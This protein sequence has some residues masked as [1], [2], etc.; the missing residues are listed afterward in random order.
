[1]VAGVQGLGL[2]DRMAQALLR[3]IHSARW[4]M[5]MLVMLCFFCSMLITNDV[6]LITFVPLALTLLPR[7]GL[8]QQLLPVV[9]LQT[10]AANLGSMLTPIGNPQNLYLYT[11]SDMPLGQFVMLLL[12]Y[13][14]ASFLL[15]AVATWCIPVKA[16]EYHAESHT[17][18]T[19]PLSGKL[20]ALYA[21]LF[22]L[23]LMAVLRIVPVIAVLVVVLIA[24]LLF[25]RKVLPRVD[26]GLLIT[27]VCF[28]IFIGNIGHLPAVAQAL[29]DLLTGREV[30]TSVLLCQVISNVPAAVL[31]SSFT[32]D[33]AALLIGTNLGGLGT[34]IASMASLISYRLLTRS[35]SGQTGRYMLQFTVVNGVFLLILLTL[36]FLL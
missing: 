25:D 28:F 21:A 8:S 22:V 17:T 30:L 26:Y 34:L 2:F 31:L 19:T 24:L 36:Y 16:G 20:L 12:P 29:E 33:H 18:A 9:V 11:L 6:A 15:L 7:S 14:L 23:S 27:F 35:V 1:V 10:V 13:T 32:A 4:L 3:H 5:E